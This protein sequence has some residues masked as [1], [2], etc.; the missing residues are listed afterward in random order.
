MVCNDLASS[1][2]QLKKIPPW[3]RFTNPPR[4]KDSLMI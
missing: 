2:S 3:Q 4:F 1:Y